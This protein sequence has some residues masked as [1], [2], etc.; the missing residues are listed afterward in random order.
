MP[1]CSVG[2]HLMVTMLFNAFTDDGRIV[3]QED[4]EKLFLN[5]G[6]MIKNNNHIWHRIITMLL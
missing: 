4:C 5:G 3:S 6:K 1:L 2:S